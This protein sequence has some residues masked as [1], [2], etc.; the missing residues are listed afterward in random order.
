MA[1]VSP[2]EAFVYLVEDLA[3]FL[4]CNASQPRA[5]VGSFIQLP[6]AECISSSFALDPSCFGSVLRKDFLT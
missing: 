5:K 4:R 6:I 3:F 2:I 1:D